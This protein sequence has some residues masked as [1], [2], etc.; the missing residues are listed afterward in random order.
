MRFAIALLCLGIF[1][2]VTIGCSGMVK[3]QSDQL[4]DEVMRFNDNVRWGRYRAASTQI[5]EARRD[6][7]VSSM[8]RAGRAFRVLDY[9]VRP[10]V[11]Q[12]DTAVV[13]VDMTYHALHDVVIK[14]VQRRQVWKKG[15]SWYLASEQ[16]VTPDRVPPPSMFPEL[17]ASPQSVGVL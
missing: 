4:R 13:V 1:A 10:Q 11:V 3:S 7:W 8:E 17:G 2:P 12:G 16:Q 6:V 15:G 9:E 5:P 14:R